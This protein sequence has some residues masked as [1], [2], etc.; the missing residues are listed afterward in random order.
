MV[1]ALA[2]MLHLDSVGLSRLEEN[3]KGFQVPSVYCCS[4]AP[5]VVFETPVIRDINAEGSACVSC[6]IW[7]IE[8]L[9]E[10]N[11]VFVA[12]GN[13]EL[14]VAG[15]HGGKKRPREVNQTDRLS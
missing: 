12:S 7:L 10:M 3:A 15:L 4:T 9:I 14:P 6:A 5:N 1:S 2:N 13:A 8:P 11:A